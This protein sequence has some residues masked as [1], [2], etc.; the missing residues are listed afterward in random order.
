MSSLRTMTMSALAGG[1]MLMAGAA[2][3]GAEPMPA[4]PLELSVPSSPSSVRADGKAHLVYELHMTNFDPRGRD[5]K[6]VRVEVAPGAGAK[7]L[8]TLE[9]EALAGVLLQPGRRDAPDKAVLGGGIRGVAFLW[10]DLDEGAP[11]PSELVHRVTIQGET[12]EKTL[13]GG[14]TPVRAGS[15]LVLGPPLRGGGWVAAVGP[16][17]TSGHRRTFITLDG[18]PRIAQRFAV[19]FAR[20]S[21]SGL[22]F[23]GD[24]RKNESWFGYGQEV[25][26]VADGVIAS[27]QDGIK[28]NVPLSPE[29]AV[30]I[31]VNTAG[32]NYAILDL[33]DG[34]YAFFAHMQPGSLR[35]KAGDRVKRGQV[36]G[37]LGNSGNSDAPHLHFHVADADSPLGSEGQS[38]VFEAFEI[39]GR[40]DSIDPILAGQPAKLS[41]SREPRRREIPV[42][43]VIVRFP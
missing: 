43:N 33:G 39:E 1:L 42:E 5:L 23:Q 41:P 40:I 19:D 37:L 13:E 25:L 16:S 10:V 11:V 9:G 29:M 30:A 31:D 21:E 12:G 2:I 24:P 15:A 7:P 22:P 3:A 17:N 6:L 35:V 14:R 38:Y 18:R 34:R 28:E 8:L 27:V 32:G 20:L 36:L 26:A 4:M